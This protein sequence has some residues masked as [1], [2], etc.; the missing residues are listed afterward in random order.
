MR[1]EFV[2]SLSPFGTPTIRL[3]GSREFL[4][5]ILQLH[6]L[7]SPRDVVSKTTACAIVVFARKTI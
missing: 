7:E 4:S 6:F 5:D 1:K 3:E 2:P